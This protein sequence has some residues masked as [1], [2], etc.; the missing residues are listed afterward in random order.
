MT[1]AGPYFWR[2]SLASPTDIRSQIVSTPASVARFAA[3][4]A[5][6]DVE[7]AQ[8]L[9]PEGLEQRAVIAADVDDQSV[10]RRLDAREDL[11]GGL[12]EVLGHALGVA[13]VIGVAVP[14][15]LGVDHVEMLHVPAIGAHVSVDRVAGL[16]RRDGAIEGVVLGERDRIELDDQFDVGRTAEAAGVAMR[17]GRSHHAV[18]SAVALSATKSSINSE[19]GS[20]SIPVSA[21]VRFMPMPL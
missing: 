17:Y 20:G 15:H 6:V 14:Q 18:L 13:G 10:L 3:S 1:C 12:T 16:A 11:V 7:D 19:S 9:F 5:G 21:V 8:A 4:V 2:M